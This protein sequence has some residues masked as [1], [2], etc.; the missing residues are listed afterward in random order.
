MDREAAALAIDAFLRALGRDPEREPELAGTGQ[1][2]AAAYADELLCGY[3]VDVDDLLAQSVFAGGS[4]LVVVRDV[5]VATT[6][7]HHLMPSTGVATV[8]FAPDE[9]LV[10]IGTVARVVD[11]F[12][13]RLALQETIGE[14]V[15]A[16]LQKHLSPRWVACRINLVHAC[17]TVRGERAHGAR[18][19]TL[20][21]AG[22][23]VESAL[24][25]A[26]LGIGR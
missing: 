23:E 18:V 21:L 15:V 22:G 8:A 9:H 1:R 14:R 24:V 7:P 17:M 10:G 4:D 12:A 3:G 5:P 11:A 6:C 25:Y 2:V 16:S 19:E 26:A 20:A 13:R